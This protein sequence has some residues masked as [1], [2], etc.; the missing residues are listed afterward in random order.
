MITSD[1]DVTSSFHNEKLQKV[2]TPRYLLNM[3]NYLIIRRLRNFLLWKFWLYSHHQNEQQQ[4]LMKFSTGILLLF[5]SL[6]Q[7]MKTNQRK[8]EIFPQG[9]SPARKKRKHFIIVFSFPAGI[10][11]FLLQQQLL[12]WSKISNRHWSSSGGWEISLS[13]GNT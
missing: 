5:F 13:W 9:F 10:E 6:W 12:R 8:W 1:L 4:Q 7:T 2:I 3:I 11:C